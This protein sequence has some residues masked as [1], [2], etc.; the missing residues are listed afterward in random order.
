MAMTDAEREQF[1]KQYSDIMVT[2]WADDDF[3]R[4]LVEAPRDVLV[5]RGIEAPADATIEVVTEGV[6]TAE[7][8]LETQLEAWEKGLTSGSIKL[9]VPKAPEL[10]QK[11]LSPEELATV[12][13]GYC[14]SCCCA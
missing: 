12:T 10:D 6:A 2:A 4:Q 11:G 3:R 7:D 8:G 9:Y 13:G 14:C 1:K 5:D